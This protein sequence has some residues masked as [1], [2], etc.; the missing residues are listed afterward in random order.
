MRN[1]EV[2]DRFLAEAKYLSL[3]K[4]VQTDSEAHPVSYSTHTGTAHPEIKLS[5][6]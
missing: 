3:F 6:N 2:V 5:G 4:I 1:P